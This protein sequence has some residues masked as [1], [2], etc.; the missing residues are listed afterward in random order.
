MFRVK[1]LETK[2]GTVDLFPAAS[3][4]SFCYVAV[5]ASRRT[6]RVWYHA[7]LPYW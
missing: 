2:S 3:R 5:D 1:A 6:A 7:H 4:N